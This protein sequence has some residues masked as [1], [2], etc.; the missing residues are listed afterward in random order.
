MEHQ[1]EKNHWEINPHTHMAWVPYIW[2]K[3]YNKMAGEKQYSFPMV[4]L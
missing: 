3:M 4:G 1:R 2:T